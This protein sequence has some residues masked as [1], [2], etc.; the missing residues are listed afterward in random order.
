MDA[1]IS[2]YSHRCP[3]DGKSLNGECL[4]GDFDGKTELI[5]FG[6]I[7]TVVKVTLTRSRPVES[8]LEVKKM[9]RALSILNQTWLQTA[10]RCSLYDHFGP[11]SI[12][13]PSYWQKNQYTEDQP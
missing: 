11:G 12:K 2:T 6:I 5:L 8:F 1:A 7:L 10:V 9:Y 3:G 13:Q 4:T